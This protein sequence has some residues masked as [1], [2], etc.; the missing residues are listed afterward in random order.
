M[1]NTASIESN[2]QNTFAADEVHQPASPAKLVE[3]PV[4][5]DIDALLDIAD[6][7]AI[8]WVRQQSGLDEVI[9]ALATCGRVALDTE[10]IKRDTY[11]PRLAL[12]QLNIG[13]HVYLLD[14]PQLQLED[15]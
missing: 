1:S 12:V 8:T 7:V 9:Q 5:P 2:P 4:E 6:E 15:F 10:F 13:D 14:A 11:Y 3:L